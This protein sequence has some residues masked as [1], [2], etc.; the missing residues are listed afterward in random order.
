MSQMSR[1]FWIILIAI[2][3]VALLVIGALAA[4][5]ACKKDFRLTRVKLDADSPRPTKHLIAICPERDSVV[6]YSTY[7]SVADYGPSDAFSLL[8]YDYSGRLIASAKPLL[9]EVPC[10]AIADSALHYTSGLGFCYYAQPLDDER[11]GKA[12][13]VLLSPKGEAIIAREIPHLE[14]Q[15]AIFDNATQSLLLMRSS[16]TEIRGYSLKNGS[17]I[18]KDQTLP[19]GERLHG[20]SMLSI[21][22]GE[23]YIAYLKDESLVLVD[24]ITWEIAVDESARKKL[25]SSIGDGLVG[26]GF[27]WLFGVRDRFSVGFRDV[28]YFPI[29]RAKK[30][31]DWLGISSNGHVWWYRDFD[32]DAPSIYYWLYRLAGLPTPTDL[33]HTVPTAASSGPIVLYDG[34]ANELLLIEPK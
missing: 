1:K 19:I 26:R 16:L 28:Y 3:A 31:G 6:I 29:L 21:V 33:E 12:Y 24:P 18:E 2:I 4:V 11:I 5:R 25:R 9:S 14:G 10:P 7:C 23:R 8:A 30:W 15:R 32:R 20:T 34:I 13:L 17:F 22:F 27:G